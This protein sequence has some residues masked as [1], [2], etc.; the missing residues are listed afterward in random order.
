MQRKINFCT[1]IS[2]QLSNVVQFPG[3]F[4]CLNAE[5]VFTTRLTVANVNL[6]YPP[7][8]NVSHF[9]HQ[10]IQR[11][12]VKVY[13]DLCEVAALANVTRPHPCSFL[14]TYEDAAFSS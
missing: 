2:T 13:V 12:S 8:P 3:E 5:E 11:C 7:P 6:S 1:E 9:Y 4:D 14:N 10:T